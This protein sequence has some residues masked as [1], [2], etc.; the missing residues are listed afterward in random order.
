MLI[1]DETLNSDNSHNHD[2]NYFNTISLAESE[3]EKDGHKGGRNMRKQVFYIISKTKFVLVI[4][5]DFMSIIRKMTEFTL[6]HSMEY[7]LPY[8]TGWI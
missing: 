6:I 5:I 2:N 7:A 4:S 1:I 3:D 8:L